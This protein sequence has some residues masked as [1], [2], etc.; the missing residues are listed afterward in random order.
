MST[1]IQEQVARSLQVAF[2]VVLEIDPN[3]VDPVLRR[4]QKP[5]IADFQANG[6]MGLAKKHGMNPRE[7]AERVVAVINFGDLAEKPEVAGPGFI[8]IKIHNSALASFVEKIDCDSLGVEPDKDSH[9]VAVDL[10][11]VNVAKQ[12]HVG[13]LR[14]TIIGDSIARMYERVG[15]KVYRENH[16]GDWGLPIAMVLEQLLSSKVN[17]DTLSIEDLNVAYKNAKLVAKDELSGEK[18]AKDTQAGPHR[19]I[20]IE[21]QNKGAVKAQLSAKEVL[22]ALQQG[23][24]YYVEGWQKLIDCTMRSV[25]ESLDLLNVKIGPEN[26][27]GE[28]FYRDKLEEVVDAFVEKGLAVEDDGAIVVRFKDQERGMIIRKSDGGFLYATTDLAAIK[29]R[30]QELQSDRLVYAV[31]ARQR[32][33]FKDLFDAASLIGWNK[34]P[35]GTTAVFTHVP[36]GSVLGEDKKPLKTRSGESVTLSSLLHEAIDRGTSEVMRRSADPKSPT[37]G[38]GDEELQTIG[39]Q[40]GIGAI[41]YADLSN[42]LVRD[43]VF[44]IDRMIAFEGS[45]GPYIQYACARITS[46]INKGGCGSGAPLCIQEPQERALALKLLQYNGVLHDTIAY[47]EPHRLCTWLYELTEAFSSFYQSC[48][49]LKFEDEQT[50]QSRLRLADLTRRVVVDGLDMLGI[51]SPEQM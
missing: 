46:L 20:E 35:D 1:N 19:L 42:D 27:R 4:A 13:H 32:D 34:T 21:E 43:Y 24:D 45:T 7:L 18:T 2:G 51:E 9:A 49:V 25:F 48:P 47:L 10:C 6:A 15:R 31:D 5:E 14:A 40:I 22:N 36:F 28:S 38:M 26:S 39:R 11:G 37:N 12:L 44:D 8:N 41:K 30:T 50:K 3:T 29:F 16:L 23:D 33:H 17:L